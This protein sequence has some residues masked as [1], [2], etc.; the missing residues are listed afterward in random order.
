M[1]SVASI[2]TGLCPSPVDVVARLA[3]RE[4]LLA[5][6]P[7]WPGLEA[8]QAV[9]K[10]LA[11]SPLRER[12]QAA[13]RLAEELRSAELF[14]A[15][16]C[17]AVRAWLRFLGELNDPLK[18]LLSPNRGLF[19]SVPFQLRAEAVRG[20]C[21]DRDAPAVAEAAGKVYLAVAALEKHLATAGLFILGESFTLADVCAVCTLVD[22]YRLAFPAA[23][24]NRHGAVL[25]W[26]ER[27]LDMPCFQE[28]GGAEGVEF[29][30]WPSEEE[31][32]FEKK[33]LN[34][35]IELRQYSQVPRPPVVKPA[36]NGSAA[37]SEAR[38]GASASTEQ[39][40]RKTSAEP[41]P[42]PAGSTE[43]DAAVK[44]R[45]EKP[46]PPPR[47]E[48]PPLS[49]PVKAATPLPP[50]RDPPVHTEPQKEVQAVAAVPVAAEVVPAAAEMAPA[51][52][53]QTP[54]AA[55]QPSQASSSKVPPAPRRDPPKSSEPVQFTDLVGDTSLAASSTQPPPLRDEPPP[56]L[57]PTRPAPASEDRSLAALG[58]PARK[59]QLT[60]SLY[61][62]LRSVMPVLL[63][64]LLGGAAAKGVQSK[65]N[66]RRSAT[67]EL[68]R[69]VVPA[70]RN[71]GSGQGVFILA[72]L[73][74]AFAERFRACMMSVSLRAFLKAAT[75]R[76]WF[77]R[78]RGRPSDEEDPWMTGA[79]DPWATPKDPWA[80]AALASRARTSPPDADAD[81]WASAASSPSRPR[82]SP[83]Q[84]NQPDPWQSGKDPWTVKPSAVETT[85]AVE[86]QPARP[87]NPWSTYQSAPT[88]QRQPGEPTSPAP[89]RDRTFE[90]LHGC[91]R[92]EYVKKHVQL[93]LQSQVQRMNLSDAALFEFGKKHFME[94]PEYLRRLEMGEVIL[95]DGLDPALRPRKPR[96]DKAWWPEEE[97]EEPPFWWKTNTGALCF[98]LPMTPEVELTSG[99]LPMYQWWDVHKISE[100]ENFVAIYKPAGMT[101]ITDEF[102]LWEVSPTNFVHVAHQRY[103]MDS[104]DEPRQRGICHRLDS[105][106]S[107][108]Q[109]FGKSWEAFRYFTQQNGSHKVQKEYIA[110]VEGRL[111]HGDMPTAGVIDVP[112][113][114]WQDSE[115]RD[116]GSCICSHEGLPAVT[117]YRAL[118]YYRVPSEADDGAK[119]FFGPEKDHWFT[120]VQLRIL[121]G[122][123]H[124]IRLHMAFIGHPLVGDMKYNSRN[125]EIHCALTPRIFLHC[126]RMEFQEYDGSTFI[127]ASDL[128]PDLQAVL[129]QLRRLDLDSR[130]EEEKA[131]GGAKVAMEG[132]FPGLASILQDTKDAMAQKTAPDGAAEEFGHKIIRQKCWCGCW[133]E[134]HVKMLQ[135]GK[136]TA[137]VFSVVRSEVTNKP[138]E[139][140][141]EPGDDGT[142]GAEGA[143]PASGSKQESNGKASADFPVDFLPWVP[144]LIQ[145]Q[146]QL[147]LAKAAGTEPRG[148]ATVEELG[149]EWAAGGSDWAWAHL[150]TR[151][152]GWIRLHNAGC[153]T[154]KWGLGNWSLLHRPSS[155]APL[156]LVTFNNT[157]HACRLMATEEGEN[158]RFDVVSVRRLPMQK[159]LAE[160]PGD[161]SALA[162]D[163]VPSCQTQGWPEEVKASTLMAS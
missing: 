43:K 163:A 39:L 161:G 23:L 162:P 14:G 145:R 74:G 97:Y 37:S 76:R 144:K 77:G 30:S 59:W 42:R 24:R 4:P 108:V 3:D 84:P 9:P 118:R 50:G 123:T 116:Y 1:A 6:T 103:R 70:L 160:D 156:L 62:T 64:I 137:M 83:V 47:R 124:Q 159:S 126:L 131:A 107:G 72:V 110:L 52:P 129:A 150:G 44:P 41:V 21:R 101:V 29:C 105:H 13:E 119:R 147:A 79:A 33:V 125:F 82:A 35:V 34:A 104:Y 157:E 95:G 46:P 89:G 109:I 85:V 121:T 102:G 155:S 138:P 133:E 10:L 136:Q 90:E 12:L 60:S 65:A 56:A 135:R 139:A 26:L 51:V 134:A 106:T 153:L 19:D 2:P 54:S 53:A 68:S 45:R 81:P 88:P 100:S 86:S 49:A 141:G 115:V 36:T 18:E 128:A 117:R 96:E 127:C 98:D 40:P 114:K 120:L 15:S 8:D 61:G 69:R 78:P 142:A 132:N 5:K 22:V 140:D 71:L 87:S 7:A 92:D 154:S 63:A 151:Q 75:R 38:A 122:R 73:A 57:K 28:L 25:R 55:V 16:D 48:P 58:K 80:N 99:A 94:Q 11:E 27:C 148:P 113:K 20:H 146:Q 31:Q 130:S 143:D 158:L 152:N 66:H 32:A 149:A 91:S 111:G 93:R 112:L 17:A 67:L